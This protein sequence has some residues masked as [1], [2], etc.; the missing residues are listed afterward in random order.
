M[1]GFVA[2]F[3]IWVIQV[4]DQQFKSEETKS[5]STTKQT[6]KELTKKNKWKLW[7]KRTTEEE[8]QTLTCMAEKRIIL[9][10]KTL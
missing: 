10:K 5:R 6:I 4:A 7:R 3:D 8:L 9:K 2:D 1:Y